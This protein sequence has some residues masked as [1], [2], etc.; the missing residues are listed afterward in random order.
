VP[1]RRRKIDAQLGARDIE[2]RREDLRW[3][4]PP[5]TLTAKVS[6]TVSPSSA[7]AP[8]QVTEVAT[9]GSR[10]TVNDVGDPAAV[11]EA[12]HMCVALQ[13]LSP[14]RPVAPSEAHDIQARLGVAGAVDPTALATRVAAVSRWLATRWPGAESMIEVPISRTMP[15]GQQVHGRIDLL[16]R[17]EDGWVLFDHKETAAGSGQWDALAAGYGGQ[18]A[19]Y[20]EAIEGVTGAPVK[21]A[22]LIL[23]T[24]GVGLRISPTNAEVSSSNSQ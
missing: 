5:Q 19:A 9:I 3:F 12:V 16:L 7:A 10:I 14:D 15:N 4:A 13:L 17:V 6:L 8:M 23:P 18:L 22:W 1:F 11:G 20:S 2:I 24:A 21:E